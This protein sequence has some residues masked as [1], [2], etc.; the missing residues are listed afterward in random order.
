MEVIKDDLRCLPV[1][2]LVGSYH[3]PAP[4]SCVCSFKRP[5]TGVLW[6]QSYT[7]VVGITGGEN[8]LISGI[9]G[10]GEHLA[11][12]GIFLNAQSKCTL[13]SRSWEEVREAS[14]ILARISKISKAYS[15]IPSLHKENQ[16]LSTPYSTFQMC[17]KMR[18]SRII[19]VDSGGLE[20]MCTPKKIPECRS[21]VGRCFNL[22]NPVRAAQICSYGYSKSQLHRSLG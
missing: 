7:D 15:F 12:T 14:G 1:Y 3:T 11:V 16:V 5:K 22:W 21:E 6:A 20:N 4:W 9:C 17:Y 18:S 13:E 2:L 19:K 8:F 10:G